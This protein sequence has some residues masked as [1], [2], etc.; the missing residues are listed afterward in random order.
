MNE[1][2]KPPKF[3]V[4]EICTDNSLGL[5]TWRGYHCELP[6]FLQRIRRRRVTSPSPKTTPTS[7]AR[8]RAPRP[9]C[10]SDGELKSDEQDAD[11]V[12]NARIG[13]AKAMAMFFPEPKFAPGA[14]PSAVVAKSA[15]LTPQR[16]LGPFCVIGETM[17][18]GAGVVMQGDDYVGDGFANWEGTLLF[19]RM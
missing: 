17:K 1:A 12:S 16:A 19:R 3:T 10:S 14:H 13:F 4:A 6:D 7:S 8:R 18:I 2:S 5:V 11:R 15:G 9:Q